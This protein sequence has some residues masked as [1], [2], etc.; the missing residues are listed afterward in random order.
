MKTT[1]ISLVVLLFLSTFLF[2]EAKAQLEIGAQIKPRGEFRNGFKTLTQ[3]DRDPVFFVEQRSRLWVS[4]NKEKYKIHINVQDVRLWGSTGQ[5]YKGDNNLFNVYEAWGEYRFT[6]KFSAKIGRMALSYDN[7]RFF[8]ALD[9]AMQGRSH[10]ALVLKY[11]N[12]DMGLKVDVGGA[13]NQTGFEPGLLE[14][15]LYTLPNYKNMQ[16]VWANKKFDENLNISALINNDGRQVRS[17]TSVAYRQTF[18]L[19]PTY[20]AGKLKFGAEFYYQTGKNAAK[21]DVNAMLASLQVTYKTDLTPITLGADY[22][23]G[24]KIDETGKD[25]AF[26]P[27]FGTN[28]KFYGFMDYFYVGNTHGQAGRTTGLL[29]Y[30]LKTKFKL[31]EKSKLAVHGHL[32]S[33]PVELRKTDGSKANSMLGTEIDLVYSIQLHKEVSLMVGYS[34]MLATESMELIKNRPDG[35]NE[36]NNWAFIQFNFSPTLLKMALKKDT[37]GK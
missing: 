30:Y 1:K 20:K 18:G 9:W 26:V 36:L 11:Q 29:D 25:N 35:R 22:V 24:T 33:S 23:S 8:G 2:N 5:I 4:F 34:H 21:V 16:F 27:L 31:T 15:N 3:K 19:I 14:K 13:F 7:E 32:F 10:D 12:K 28:H 37:E 17:D 6:P